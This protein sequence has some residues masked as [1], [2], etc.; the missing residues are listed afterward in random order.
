MAYVI[1][2]PCHGQRCAACYA[3]CP[4]EAIGGGYHDPQMYI[5]PDR[6]IECGLCQEACPSG[7]VFLE[8]D[9]PEAWAEYARLNREHF[10]PPTA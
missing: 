3:V 7:A 2:E 8:E 1:A 9:L 4:A 6:C 10:R 5:D